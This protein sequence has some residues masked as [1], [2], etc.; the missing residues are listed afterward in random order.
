MLPLSL[1]NGSLQIRSAEWQFSARIRLVL[2]VRGSAKM[3]TASS[4]LDRNP[5]VP[6]PEAFHSLRVYTKKLTV[7]VHR[8]R[9][10]DQ[11]KHAL[12]DPGNAPWFDSNPAR[13]NPGSYN[14]IM[15]SD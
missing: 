12:A 3:R 7:A 15:P 13:R 2:P 14:P 9:W 11:I 8:W 5:V 1:L 4:L 10:T 6:A